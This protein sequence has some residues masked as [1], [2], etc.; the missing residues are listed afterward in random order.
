M[1]PHPHHPWWLR[2]RIL[3]PLALLA[4]LAVTSFIAFENSDT[5]TIVIYNET[6]RTLP[7]LLVRA[8]GQTWTFSRLADQESVRIALNPGSGE[9]A[10]RLELA[11]APPWR[12]D[13]DVIQSRGG[14]RLSIRLWPEGQ[15]ESFTDVSWWR[16]SGQPD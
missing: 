7:P 1:N 3:F 15:V 11:T 8:G 14:H 10:V 2:K 6:G 12:W 16:R 9:S 5:S 13:G 4:G